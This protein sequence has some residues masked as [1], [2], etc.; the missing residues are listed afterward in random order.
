MELNGIMLRRAWLTTACA[1]SAWLLAG[2]AAPAA[3]PPA[4][5]APAPAPTL[6]QQLKALGF[7]T[8]D[9][10]WEFSLHG[11]LLFGND[12]DALDAETLATAEKLGRQLARLEVTRVRVEG[13][14][15]NTGSAAYNQQLSLRRAQAV[16]RA[17]VTAGMDEAGIRAVGMGMAA[18]I[19]GN[20]SPEQRQQN[21][22]VAIVV[23]AQ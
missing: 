19:T 9:D 18:P 5:P 12:S 10:G 20:S 4:A 21:R 2:C 1:G 13:H 15:D 11:K 17:M 6:A 22:R 3:P 14:T 23:P 8:T 7:Q 16:V